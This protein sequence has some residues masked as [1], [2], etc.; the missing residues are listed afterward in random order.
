MLHTTYVGYVVMVMEKTKTD[1]E[2]ELINRLALRNLNN[3]L[4]FCIAGR[5]LLVVQCGKNSLKTRGFFIRNDNLDSLRDDDY[6]LFVYHTMTCSKAVIVQK[7]QLRSLF[8]RRSSKNRCFSV[9]KILKL[10]ESVEL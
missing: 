8:F 9:E 3:L 6:I 1:K 2:I 7:R 5:K 4:D 10:A